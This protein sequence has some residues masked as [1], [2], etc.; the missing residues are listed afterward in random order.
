MRDG[1]KEIFHLLIHPQIFP[2]VR[3]GLGQSQE[4]GTASSSLTWV[5]ETQGLAPSFV[6]F[7][8]THQQE[9]GIG[10][11]PGTQTQAFQTG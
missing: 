2:V 3:A 11:T 6:A 1:Q 9:A 4:L 10:N 8:G 7:Q 5:A